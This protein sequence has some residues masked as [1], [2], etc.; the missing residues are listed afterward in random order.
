MQKTYK[1]AIACMLFLGRNGIP[2]PLSYPWFT[3]RAR[4][5]EGV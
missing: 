3:L 2:C 1:F 4:R 5:I